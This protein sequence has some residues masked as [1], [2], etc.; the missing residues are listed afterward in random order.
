M[1]RIHGRPV[2]RIPANTDGMT[3]GRLHA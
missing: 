2:I 3:R 1:N